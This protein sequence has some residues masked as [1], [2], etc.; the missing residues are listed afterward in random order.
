MR[1]NEDRFSF[2]T[3]PVHAVQ[4]QAVKVNIQVGGRAKALDQRD[5]AAV[6]SSFGPEVDFSASA[7]DLRRASVKRT[8]KFSSG[9]G[10]DGTSYATAITTGAAALWLTHRATEISR[11]YPQPWQR[12]EAFRSLACRTARVPAVWQPGSF[13]T[14]VLNVAALL[15]AAL[16][17]ANDLRQAS[18]A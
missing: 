4:H 13:G 14:G 16:P 11:A 17:A 8:A 15:D 10:G 2:G 18:A 5:R 1:I 7:A 9:F 6:G 12:V 3:A